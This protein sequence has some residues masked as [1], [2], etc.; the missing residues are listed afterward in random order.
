M[1]DSWLRPVPAGVV[2][3]LYVAGAGVG[4]GY[5]RRAGLTAS[6]FLACP[7]GQ[8]GQRM[9]RT[10]DL[11]HWGPDGQLRYL[12]RSDDQ[13]KIRGY[14]IELGEVQS[15]LT[16]LDGVTHAAVIAREDRPGDKRLVG[17][18][19]GTADLTVIR[20][21]LAERLPAYMVPAAV[22]V[23]D[24][25][26]MTVNG[27]LDIRALP[28]PEY[29]AGDYRA[30]ASAVEEILAG[31][32]AEV[33]GVDRVGVDD[34]FFDLGG[35]SLSAMRLI[36]AINTSLDASLAVRAI[37]EAPTVAELALLIRADAGRLEPL[38]AVERPA[39]VPL[40]YAQQ[41]L[42]LLDQWQ[43]PSPVYNMVSALRLGGR[44]DV[45]ALVAALA[46]VVGRQES[47]RTVVVAPDGIPQ[48]LLVPPGRADFGW[49]V[50][51]ATGWS[52]AQLDEAAGDAVRYTFNLATEIPLRTTLFRLAEDEHVLVAVL[53]HIAAD[54][55]SIAP[56]LADLG[57]AYSSR[58]AGQPPDWAPLPVQYVDYTLWQRTLLG[59]LTD[60][61]GPIAAQLAYWEQAL[62][63]L[64]ERLELPTDRPYPAV[65]DHRGASAAVKWP[66]QL[67]QQI[68]RV[69]R[70]HNA[71]SFMVV[72]AAL[73]AL[74][75]KLSA[76]TD[77]AVGFAVAGRGDP[78]LDELVGF[79][80]NTLV[81]RVDLADDPTV[82]ELLAQV[83]QRGLEAYEHQDVPF[84]VLVERL[85][86]T[87]SMTH[88]PVFQVA[89]A[90]QNNQPPTLALGDL[91]VTPMP[92]DTRTARMDMTFA[93]AECFTEAGEPAGID[94]AVEFRTDVFDADSIATMIERLERVLAAITADPTARLSSI[95][96][97]DAT[98]HT[99][100]DEIGNRAVLNGPAA[101][102]AR[103]RCR[104]CSPS[105]CCELPRRSRSP[106][107]SIRGPTANS[108]MPQRDWRIDSSAGAQGRAIAWHCCSSVRPRRSWR[109]WR[110]SR[111]ARPICRSTRRCRRRGWSSC[112]PTRRRS[113]RSRLAICGRDSTGMACR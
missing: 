47:L 22:V 71:T 65:A 91:E 38:L 98:E 83:R 70:A 101:A 17:Y 106:P 15:A 90:W 24:A 34:S 12:G 104:R 54:G 105:T 44:L 30:P 74:L 72:Q 78:A 77:V 53:H 95:G 9:Y 84:E 46:D 56:L 19:T 48:Q 13:V 67:Q 113:R 40:S 16:E 102:F 68:A 45:D 108:T 37:F 112:S 89:L 28:A 58:C 60:S 21:Q 7:F 42:W 69:G 111:P 99:R 4:I 76:S 51:D 14:R 107:G 31:I 57:A 110:C 55:W 27:K 52:A 85:N 66:A 33:L 35:D 93:F 61:D 1:L 75:S 36:A 50:V 25:L 3:E 97:L 80:V 82:A 32:Y 23:F 79:F 88:H 81:L 109:S 41:R 11:V 100:L 5:L 29:T 10:G 59:D 39:V 49:E 2:G 62:A 73:A 8:P 64:P 96:V 43:G 6:R 18:V 63:G 103:C 92:V 87:R 20:A 86:P 26:P 94:G